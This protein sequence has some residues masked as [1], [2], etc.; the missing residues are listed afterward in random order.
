MFALKLVFVGQFL[1]DGEDILGKEAAVVNYAVVGVEQ[2]EFDA[3]EGDGF[4][5]VD[6][7]CHVAATGDALL[8]Q[9]DRVC[10]E[11]LGVVAIFFEQDFVRLLIQFGGSDEGLEVFFDYQGVGDG[12][13]FDFLVAKFIP[14]KRNEK[15]IL[16]VEFA[17][18]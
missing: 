16:E 10:Y 1:N 13:G 5:G 12:I 7:E 18:R 8:D 15:F 2:V 11:L 3:L 9:G 17:H 14:K 6:Q 4:V